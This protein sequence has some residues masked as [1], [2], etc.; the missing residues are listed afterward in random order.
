AA[1]HPGGNLPDDAAWW[2]TQVR[3]HL[4]QRAAAGP[5][6]GCPG[7]PHR[8]RPAPPAVLRSLPRGPE[9]HPA[10]WRL[11]PAGLSQPP[12]HHMFGLLEQD[13]AARV[14]LAPLDQD[15]VTGM[16]T[17]AF[18][19]PPDQALADL[20]RGAAGNPSL[21]AELIGGLRDDNAVRVT[22]GRAVL[23]SARL[24]RRIHQL[25]QRRLDNLRQRGPHLLG[26][27]AG[28]RPALHPGG[29]GRP[30]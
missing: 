18:G 23:T 24:P 22:A 5:G 14:T 16:F 6:P 30:A 10:A 29:R 15:A 4:E 9:R 26:A 27:A 2:I 25:A 11:A 19:T 17:D 20:A 13:G 12:A 21:V 7:D 3:A 8:A 1:E 28:G